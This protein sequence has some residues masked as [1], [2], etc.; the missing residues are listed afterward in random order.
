MYKG[1]QSASILLFKSLSDFYFT[2]H[3]YELCTEEDSRSWYIQASWPE[4]K[5]HWC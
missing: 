3:F 4:G 2:V 1:G 5:S